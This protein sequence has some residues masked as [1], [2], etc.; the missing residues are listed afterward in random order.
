MIVAMYLSKNLKLILFIFFT[1]PFVYF[2]YKSQYTTGI[3]SLIFVIISLFIFYNYSIK[4]LILLSFSVLL[5]FLL[6]W[7]MF[8]DQFQEIANAQTYEVS[9]RLNAL[10]D[11]SQG[12]NNNS[13]TLVGRQTVYMKSI[14]TFISSPILGEAIFTPDSDGGHSFILDFLASFGL[15][16]I[17]AL[18]LFY[19]HILRNFYKS[20]KIQPYYG[21]MILS[22]SISL[23]LSVVNTSP[24]IFAIGFFVPLVAYSIK[25]KTYHGI[26]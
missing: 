7:P 6:F 1:L 9:T 8:F 23:F 5:I 3:I 22:F 2:V 14:I 15:I 25:Y 21:Y 19:V 17:I 24:N 20:Y 10:I 4:K 11:L 13:E 18:Y 26:S 16:G 12:K